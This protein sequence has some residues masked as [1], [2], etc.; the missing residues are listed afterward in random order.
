M[1]LR[2][3]SAVDHNFSSKP[4][5]VIYTSPLDNEFFIDE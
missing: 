4:I 1:L 2:N 3:L 5:V